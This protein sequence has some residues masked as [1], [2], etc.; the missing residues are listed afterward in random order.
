MNT[1]ANRPE[2]VSRGIIELL[3]SSALGGIL[4]I[5][6]TIIALIWANSGWQESYHHLW[7]LKFGVELGN[8]SLKMDLHHWIND[9]LMAI[10]FYMV[11][12]EIKREVISGELSSRKK[13]TLPALG[14]LG[15]MLFPALIYVAI[16]ASIGNPESANGWG[17]PMA[18]D[19][20]FSL[21]IIS[22]LGKRVPL[23]LKVFLVALAIVDDLGA[24]LVIAI[25]YTAE[26]NLP[27]LFTGLGLLVFLFV[28]D[29]MKFRSIAFIH[30]VGL[31]VW[32]CFLQSGVHATIAGVLLAFLTPI[33]RELGIS[34]FHKKVREV[35][36]D[37]TME[38]SDTLPHHQ[39]EKY[40]AL[41]RQLKQIQSPV[42]RLE[43]DLHHTVNYLIMPVF[44]LANAGVAFN[45]GTAIFSAVSIAVAVGLFVG[46]SIGI[47]FF[48]WLGC[49][50]GMAE[51]PEGINFKNILGV[52][53]LGGLGFTMAIFI[54]SLAFTDPF[55]LDQSK[56]GIFIGSLFSGIIGSYALSIMFPKNSRNK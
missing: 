37:K 12:L 39:L 47:T 19:I 13:A 42:Q 24:I 41:R 29:R 55:M 48:A 25:F 22:L 28:L 33:R 14:A 9:G 35:E 5:L 26:L 44:A 8:F 10:F 50:L 20:A 1:Y 16:N 21:G 2:R 4:L 49:K 53:I 54:A 17:V 56:I 6:F 46:K 27:A 32:Y 30:L 15:G 34:V 51:L 43:H 36:Y 40:R 11:G 45:G 31:L 7:H 18:T 38:E 23:A 52:A 3:Q